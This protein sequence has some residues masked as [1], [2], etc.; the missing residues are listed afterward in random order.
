M[1]I[2]NDRDFTEKL[3]FCPIVW[4]LALDC[5][6]NSLRSQWCDDQHHRQS[7][8]L[9]NSR[10]NCSQFI[11]KHFR[12]RTVHLLV[13]FQNLKLAGSWRSLECIFFLGGWLCGCILLLTS[14]YNLVFRHFSNFT[15]SPFAS[16]KFPALVFDFFPRCTCAVLYNCTN[17]EIR[18]YCC[19][20]PQ[21]DYGPSQR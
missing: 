4:L 1:F 16:W 14:P 7:S 5:F 2:E 18:A 12:K 19:L 9:T 3:A 15:W 10:D 11:S 8:P 13:P 6:H 21:S 20:W 17:I